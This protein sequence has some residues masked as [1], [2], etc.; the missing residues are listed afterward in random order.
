MFAKTESVGGSRGGDFLD[1]NPEAMLV[2]LSV[3]TTNFSGH[4]VIG[5][6]QA[7]Y[8]G[9]HGQ[10]SGERCGRQHGNA[11][12]LLAKPG[13]AIGGISAFGG[14]RFAGFRIVFMRVQGHQLDPANSYESDWVGGKQSD[15]RSRLGCDGNPV[16]GIF[17]KSGAE[18]DSLGLIQLMPGQGRAPAPGAAVTVVF[19]QWG[20]GANASIERH[21]ACPGTGRCRPGFHRQCRELEV[22][23]APGTSKHLR[24][25][26]RK[27]GKETKLLFIENDKVEPRQ[28]M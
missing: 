3:T 25:L 2:G 6:V 24:I 8:Q 9:R 11:I 22:G 10:V 26:Y 17:G 12:T 20:R 13:Y 28:F 27:N 19:A 14:I 23:P 5:S 16:V 18:I 4:Q 21:E 1:C 15:E 7:I